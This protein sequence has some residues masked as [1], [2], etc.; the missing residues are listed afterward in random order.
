MVIETSNIQDAKIALNFYIREAW[1]ATGLKWWN[2][3][4]A[5]V[6]AIVD[7]IVAGI[8]KELKEELKKGDE[9]E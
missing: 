4:E 3:N 1:K 9:S 5:E 8:K 6:N 7:D 2:D